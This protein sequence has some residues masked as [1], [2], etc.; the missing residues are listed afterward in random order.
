VLPERVVVSGED[1]A[2]LAVGPLSVVA[3]VVELPVVLWVLSVLPSPGVDVEVDSGGA[4]VEVAAVGGL[5]SGGSAFGMLSMALGASRVEGVPAGGLV[6]AGGVVAPAAG[7]AVAG[8]AAGLVAA[9]G[10]GPFG[11]TLGG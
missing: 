7:L 10:A 9:G 11:R 8:G 6:W 5:G 1:A 3:L 2:A 4:G